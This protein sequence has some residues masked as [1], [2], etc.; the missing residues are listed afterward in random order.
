MLSALA[1]ALATCRPSFRISSM[2]FAFLEALTRICPL[3]SS[4]RKT[5][6]VHRFTKS[7]LSA[8]AGGSI[9]MMMTVVAAVVVGQRAALHA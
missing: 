8:A 7:F 3:A 9:M 4:N 1:Y 6:G 5:P 2:L